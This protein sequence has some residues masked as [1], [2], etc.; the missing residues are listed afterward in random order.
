MKK[1]FYLFLMIMVLPACTGAQVTVR[2]WPEWFLYPAKFPGVITGYGVDDS[3]AREDAANNYSLFRGCRVTG[4]LNIYETS[5]EDDPGRKSDYFY[6]FY[7]D[8][9]KDFAEKFIPVDRYV[10]NVLSN[11]RIAAFVLDT[12]GLVRNFRKISE[13]PEPA[14]LNKPMQSDE[15][16]YYGTGIFSS[17]GNDVDAWK[18]AEEKG[19]FEILRGLSITISN[20]TINT[21]SK[22]EGENL[23]RLSVYRLNFLLRNIEIA[24]RYPDKANSVYH[25]L[26]R[27]KKKDVLAR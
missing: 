24:E 2:E 12:G 5:D 14:W 20:V 18:S 23:E 27:I 11:S 6:D 4:E 7:R 21:D 3:T 13:P 16:Y 15:I 9:S 10:I 8:S 19:I 1:K 25:V 26:V 17:S 22:K